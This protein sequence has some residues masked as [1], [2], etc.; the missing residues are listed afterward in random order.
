MNADGSDQQQLTNDPDAAN[1][2]PV[3][4]PTG[5]EIAFTKATPTEPPKIWVMNADGSAPRALTT[6]GPGLREDIDPA[7]SIDGRQ[8]AFSRRPF[9]SSSEI[10]IMDADGS[11]LTALTNEPGAD[12]TPTFSPDGRSIAWTASRAG[13][14]DVWVM[15]KDGSGKRRLTTEPGFDGFPD[16]HQVRLP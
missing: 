14:F 15:T 4:S 11:N 16:W 1:L 12:W 2:T 9:G 13:N 10:V 5:R 6:P 7:W 3:V 8:I